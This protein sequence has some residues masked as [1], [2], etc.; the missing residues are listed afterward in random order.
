MGQMHNTGQAV[1][2]TFGICR[3]CKPMDVPPTRADALELDDWLTR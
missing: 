2:R 3:A 1:K